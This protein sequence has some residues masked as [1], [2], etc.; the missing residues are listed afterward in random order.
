MAE[1]KI[2]KVAIVD[3]HAMMRDGLAQLV[4]GLEGYECCWAAGN[5]AAALAGVE[6]ERP[7]LLITDMSLPGRNGLELIK[8]VLAVAMGL[9]ILVL[10]MHD[11]TLYAQR[12]LRAG[13]KG[14]IMKDADA[15][16]LAE[17]ITTIADGGIWVSPEMSSKIIQ[18]FS[19]Q[20]GKEQVEGVHRLTDREFEIFQLI[21][22]GVS[23]ADISATLN[24]SPKT[25]DVHKAH[26]REK[27]ELENAA[28]VMSYAIRWVEIRK[29]G[30]E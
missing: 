10:S 21:G 8:D 15:L 11:E 5:A 13:A 20:G 12:V 29:L 16:K 22:E 25:V 4:A 18:A 9:P 23:K 3:D 28:A 17:A 6:K 1:N 2:R 26:I 27:L 30:S 24:I 14:Y 7:D 19:G